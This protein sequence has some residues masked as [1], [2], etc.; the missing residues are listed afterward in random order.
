MACGAMLRNGRSPARKR[1]LNG[2][3]LS[4]AQLL[5]PATARV[6]HRVM[7]A[8]KLKVDNSFFCFSCLV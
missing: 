2:K 3:E 4:T 6:W 7:V 1:K 8:T 5:V